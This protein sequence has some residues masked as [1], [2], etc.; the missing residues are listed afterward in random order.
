MKKS[1]IRYRNAVIALLMILL[2][3]AGAFA[4]APWTVNP[5]DYRYDMSLYLDVQFKNE[6]M[7]YSLYDVAA[8][9]GDECRGVAEVLSL[10]NGKQVL[11]LRARSNQESGE[12]MTFKYCNKETQEILPI[13]G[14]S[15]TFESNGRLGYPS[16]P[17]VVT[18]IRHFDVNLS[19]GVGGTVDQESGR[20][21]EGT[22]LTVTAVPSEGYHFEKWSDGETANPRTITVNNDVTLEAEFMVNSYKLV[23][24][25]DD[26]E[27]KSYDI[28]YGTALTA[29][30]APV[31]EGYTF[32]GWSGLPETMPAHDVTVTGSFSINTYN[33]VFKIGGEVVA[34]VPTVFNEPVVAPAAPEKEGHTFAGWQ[35]V[36]ERMPAHDI[37]VQ[38]SYTVNSYKLVYMVDDVEYK[39]YDVDYGTALTA[40]EAPVKEG[41]T[42]S[43]WSGL[44][45]TMPA[46]DV[47]VYGSFSINTYNAVFKIGGE[48]V[49]TV[50]TVFNEPVV[51]PAAPEKEGHTFAGW[52]DVP[53]R[54]P[55]HDIEVQGS[56][57]VNSYKLVYMVDDVEYK[58]YDV[59]YGTALTAEE[60]PVKEGYTFSGWEGLP[61][62]MP[63]HDVTVYGSF[64]VNT[65]NAV[66]KI[67]E[68]VVATVPTV[69]NEPVVAPAAPEKEGHT[70]AGWQDVPELMPAHDIEVQGSYTV[71][72]YKLVYM[73]D[74]AE[75][76]TY[77]VD[78]G[79]A[80]TAEDAPVKD[81]YT[82]S[83]WSGLPETMPAHDVTVKGSFTINSYS[84][85]F[86]IDEEVIEKRTI[87]FGEATGSAPDA[88]V[89]EGYTFAGWEEYPTLM[90]AHDV[91]VTGTYD[92]NSYK[93]TI[94]LDGKEYSSETV[95]YGAK[96]DIQE[97]QAPEG[98]EFDKWLDEIP[99]TMPAHDLDLHAVTKE[100]SSVMQIEID[101]EEHVTVYT[102]SGHVLFRNA[103]WG[104]VRSRLGS[105]LYII[106]GMKFIIGK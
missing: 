7:D 36:P 52:Q 102:S 39:S 9:C 94:Y 59:D 103:A 8:F 106:N 75:Y 48:V 42:F 74:G 56:Y 54:M 41:Y 5:S 23:Y 22:E 14:V 37:E 85:S 104:D 38:G 100:V 4:S 89:R 10:S 55:A 76:K 91:T 25:V 45:E 13:D 28:D 53:E 92:V 105:G 72:S 69:F 68:E 51:A 98:R 101:S 44:P 73:V 3:G 80:L 83:G 40:E 26:A 33:A 27:Y 88:P 18:I 66:F 64:S 78:Y 99:E 84:L 46:Y 97:P 70:F 34:T 29:E 16:D 50:P 57:T 12:T 96:L 49:A 95:E 21:A 31:K 61:E 60:A 63:A 17:Y 11:Y 30:D 32:S 1:I 15:F 81:G 93:L 77:D 86:V 6:A 43:G 2:N 47:T 20:F 67:G 62:T 82:F 19:A 35:D 90:P 87:V 24:M 71:N 79:T 65:Y 58:S